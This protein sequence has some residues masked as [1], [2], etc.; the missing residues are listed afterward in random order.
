MNQRE[1]QPK[2]N[3]QS[4]NVRFE[5][6]AWLAVNREIEAPRLQIVEPMEL[7]DE[8]VVDARLD[9]DSIIRA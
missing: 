8:H 9:G 1:Q 6:T 4:S 7:S 5:R 3:E 2:Q